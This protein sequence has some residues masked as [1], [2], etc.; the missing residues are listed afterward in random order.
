MNKDRV[1]MI[2]VNTEMRIRMGEGTE[3]M[4]TPKI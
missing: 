2:P 1:E 3:R 4:K